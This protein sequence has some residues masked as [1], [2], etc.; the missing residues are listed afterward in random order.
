MFLFPCYVLFRAVVFFELVGGW[1]IRNGMVPSASALF[2]FIKIY[3]ACELLRSKQV[4]GENLVLVFVRA[5]GHSTTNQIRF[6]QSRDLNF[7]GFFVILLF[8][9]SSANCYYFLRSYL[10]IVIISSSVVQLQYFDVNT[11]MYF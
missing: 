9:V 8:L 5:L 10:F 1:R 4:T 3:F 11:F 7:C 6:R 2:L